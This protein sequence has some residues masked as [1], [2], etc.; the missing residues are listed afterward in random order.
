MDCEDCAGLEGG[1]PGEGGEQPGAFSRAADAG[2]TSGSER[3][4]GLL[5]WA[6]PRN[7]TPP[8]WLLSLGLE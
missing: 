6:G 8:T 7:L 5:W 3:T 2:T 1:T 4:S